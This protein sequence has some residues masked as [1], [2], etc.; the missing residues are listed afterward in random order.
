VQDERNDSED[1]QDV[2]KATRYVKNAHTQYPSYQQHHKQDRKDTHVTSSIF[3]S[4]ACTLKNSVC[5][6]ERLV[7]TAQSASC[8]FRPLP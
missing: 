8:R 6:F 7:K 4:I 5:K 1:E 2:N 3:S